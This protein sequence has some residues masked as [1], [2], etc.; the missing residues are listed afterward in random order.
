VAKAIPW[1]FAR[2]LKS[3]LILQ[4]KKVHSQLRHEQR[5][6]PV[7][8]RCAGV[9]AISLFSKWPWVLAGVS[10]R[11]GRAVSQILG[12]RDQTMLLRR[13]GHLNHV[14]LQGAHQQRWRSLS[15]SATQLNPTW[16]YVDQ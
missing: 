10:S 13:Y 4:A 11:T 6:S 8:S 15:A 7:F 5:P 9:I 16:L 14:S 1:S 3:S 2:R 12:H